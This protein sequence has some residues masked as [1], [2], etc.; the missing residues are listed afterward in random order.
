M[1]FWMRRKRSLIRS[2]ECV[3][4]TSPQANKAVYP[5]F[6]TQRRHQKFKTGLPG[7]PQKGPMSSN[8]EKTKRKKERS[9]VLQCYKAP[10]STTDSAIAPPTC[11]FVARVT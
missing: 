10:S 11:K 2:K 8:L 5:G 3:T 6:E 1:H 4:R 9:T 7:A